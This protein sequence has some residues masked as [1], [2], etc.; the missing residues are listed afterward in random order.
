MSGGGQD[1]PFI[2]L[3]HYREPDRNATKWRTR[4]AMGGAIKLLMHGG[5]G[6]DLD[7][8]VVDLAVGGGLH[9]VR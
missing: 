7:A 3:Q 1:R 4:C 5:R 2:W 9:R 6:A 8:R